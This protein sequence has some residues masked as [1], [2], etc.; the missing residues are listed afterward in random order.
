MYKYN[1][2]GYCPPVVGQGSAITESARVSSNVCPR[3]VING[4][5]TNTPPVLVPVQTTPASQT[6]QALARATLLQQSDPYN[7]ATRF[8]QYYPPA[9]IPEVITS[10][11]IISKMNPVTSVNQCRPFVRYESTAETLRRLSTF[12]QT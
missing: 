6:T 4:V 11:T 7:P 12:F 1:S 10:T 3:C 5:V 8:S 2:Q 9:S